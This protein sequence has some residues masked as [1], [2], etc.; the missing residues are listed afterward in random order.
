MCLL[1]VHVFTLQ[2][3]GLVAVTV[4]IRQSLKYCLILYRKSLLIS[5]LYNLVEIKLWPSRSLISVQV[6]PETFKGIQVEKYKY[7]LFLFPNSCLYQTC[8]C[9]NFQVSS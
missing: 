5:A 6:F 9:V 3:Y 7:W 8:F 1:P 4:N 2:R